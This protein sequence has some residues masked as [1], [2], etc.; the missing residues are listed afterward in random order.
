MPTLQSALQLVSLSQ[1]DVAD[2]SIDVG[3]LVLQRHL[4]FFV[5]LHFAG[6]IC[7]SPRH[8]SIDGDPSETIFVSLSPK[9]SPH[10][11]TRPHP[12][13]VMLTT[14]IFYLPKSSLRIRELDSGQRGLV[15][16]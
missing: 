4:I 16:I 3:G 9:F 8:F 2:V 14:K 12:N 7:A 13:E 1:A 6:Y 10:P 15:P 5:F 11:S